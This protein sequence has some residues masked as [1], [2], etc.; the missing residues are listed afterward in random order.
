MGLFR[1]SKEP[2]LP[3]HVRKQSTYDV[4]DPVLTAIRDEEPFQMSANRTVMNGDAE[5]TISPDMNTRDHFGQPISRPDRSNP[6]RSRNERPLDTI[7]T[8]EYA[9]T[10]DERL[11]DE[12]ETAR[13]GWATRPNFAVPRFDSNPYAAAQS[14]APD[15]VMFGNSDGSS[16]GQQEQ[17]KTYVPPKQEKKKRGIFGRK[18]K[19]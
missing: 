18:K 9:C 2:E 1:K 14:S 11:R 17:F 8:F 15:M 13:F 7:R 12:M 4:Q 16:A 10:G 3:G 5:A 19:E 6:S